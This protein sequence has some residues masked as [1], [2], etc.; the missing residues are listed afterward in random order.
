MKKSSLKMSGAVPR[1]FT[2]GSGTSWEKTFVT[3]EA[4]NAE[5][6]KDQLTAPKTFTGI[7]DTVST[8][9]Y[10]GCSHASAFNAARSQPGAQN[11]S[12]QAQSS[13]LRGQDAV[14]GATASDPMPQLSD[15]DEYCASSPIEEEELARRERMHRAA[16]ATTQGALQNAVAFDN[17]PATQ[18]RDAAGFEQKA[19]SMPQMH[20]AFPPPHH[21]P[22][23]P[24]VAG[25]NLMELRAAYMPQMHPAFPFP[26]GVPRSPVVPVEYQMD[27]AVDAMPMTHEQQQHMTTWLQNQQYYEPV[28]LYYQPA[29]QPVHQPIHQPHYYQVDPNIPPYHYQ[30]NIGQPHHFYQE[31]Y[32]YTP[33]FT[34]AQE[35]YPHTQLGPNAVCMQGPN[36]DVIYDPNFKGGMEPIIPKHLPRRW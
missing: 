7:G 3:Y 2:V 22:R 8:H 12:V 24:A 13:S 14:T 29:H 23:S 21:V 25:E 17:Y 10:V 34:R 30:P 15:F 31:P 35:R 4:E 32:A 11:A 28:P 9:Q 6:L 19:A 5:E 26:H 27:P 18:H 20:A 1:A 36:G 16:A 33:M